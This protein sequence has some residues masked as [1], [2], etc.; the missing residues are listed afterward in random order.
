[1]KD[2]YGEVFYFNG[3]YIK[4]QWNEGLQHGKGF[5]KRFDNTME[6]KAEWY[7]GKLVFVDFKN[8]LNRGK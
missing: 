3:G 1:L 5:I 7:Q 8:E 6:V 4:C 2:G